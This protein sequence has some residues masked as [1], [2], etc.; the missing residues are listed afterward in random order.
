MDSTVTFAAFTRRVARAPKTEHK[1]NNEVFWLATRPFSSLSLTKTDSEV[2]GGG[3]PL[4][5]SVGKR[6]W[7]VSLLSPLLLS[8]SLSSS[9]M[10][11]GLVSREGQWIN[12][13][14]FPS[15]ICTI[16]NNAGN[17][18]QAAHSHQAR[19]V[20]TR[21]NPPPSRI[22]AKFFFFSFKLSFVISYEPDQSFVNMKNSFFCSCFWYYKNH[23]IPHDRFQVL[24]VLLYSVSI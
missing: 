4:S 21:I 15:K 22:F 3:S 5:T 8:F 13:T 14:V 7:W 2:S 18:C 12:R 23:I 1:R 17:P 20:S 24:I 9:S 11:D 10:V 19:A 6:L 16:S